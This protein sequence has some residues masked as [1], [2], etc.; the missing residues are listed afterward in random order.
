MVV[1]NCGID[2]DRRIG[3]CEEIFELRDARQ[4]VTASDSIS[5]PINTLPNQ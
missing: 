3:K 5:G 4:G 1:R 2:R